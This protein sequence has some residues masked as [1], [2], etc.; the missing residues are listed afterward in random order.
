MAKNAAVLPT[1]SDLVM[2]LPPLRPEQEKEMARALR[3]L[4]RSVFEAVPDRSGLF[5]L[6]AAG[7]QALNA[8]RN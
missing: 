6:S 3:G 7:L 2:N 8:A 5:K 4:D 1:L